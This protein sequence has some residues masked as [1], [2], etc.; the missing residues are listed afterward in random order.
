MCPCSPNDVS[1]PS[2]TVPSGP[3]IPGFG[4]PFALP[5][6][7]NDIAGTFNVVNG[8]TTV[9]LFP[10]PALPQTIS[11][12]LG[13]TLNFSSQP[14]NAY[15]VVFVGDTTMNVTP[16]YTG[17]TATSVTASIP[18]QPYPPAGFPEDLLNLF[19]QFQ[20]LI[21]PG[22]LKPSLNPNF[23]KDIFDTILSMMDQFFPFLMLYKFFL[24]VLN[25]IICIIEVLCALMNPF[26]LISAINRLFSQC[27]PEFLNLFPIFA[28]VIMIISLLSLLLSLIEYIASQILKLVN[29]ILRN[30]NA[31]TKAFQDADANGVLAIAQ[32]L[33]SLLCAFQNVFV[34]LSIF[35]VVI[36]V[37]KDI[38]RLSFPIP[39]CESGSNSGCCSTT[40]CP[41][42]ITNNY[43]NTTGTFQYLPEIGVGFSANIPGSAIDLRAESWQLYDA[44]QTQAQA[45]SNI[46]NA[47]DI[48]SSV[49]PKPIFF[50]TDSLYTATTAVNQAPYT[51]N[52]RLFYNPASWGRPGSA[53]YIRFDNCIML[54]VPSPN[55]VNYQNTN[56]SEPTGVI[57]VAGG[58][59]YED[60]NTTV[61]T[62]FASNGTTPISSQA[63]LNN[64]LHKPAT[65]T[66]TYSA[67]PP[68]PNDGYTFS[69]ATYTFTP[70]QEV[71]FNKQITTLGCEP[72]ITLNRTFVNTVL[73]GNVAVQT[74]T[75]NGLVNSNNF[76][77][78]N[79]ALLCLTTALD[80][81]RSNLSN[82]GVAQFQAVS[83]LCLN[84]LQN[85]ANTSL[86]SMVGIGF[87]PCTSTMALA[88]S[89]QFTSEKIVVSVNLNENN[90]ISLTQNLPATVAATLAQ[91][92]KG[93]PTFG[94]ITNFTYDGYQAFIA[95]ITSPA[96]GSGSLMVSFDN[97]IFC[98]NTLSADT[99][100][101]S[102]HT[103]QQLPYQFVYS[104]SVPSGEPRRDPG[105]VARDGS[106]GV[107]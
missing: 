10:N 61:L 104:P 98:T 30:I 47:F 92:I 64:F 37:I 95:E 67:P 90:G 13:T 41:E 68:L 53:R 22:V 81:L 75:L 11:V 3:P 42:I 6:T 51:I 12:A 77:D 16:G 57:Y 46:Y 102:T 21:P 18:A 38:L 62:G 55:L 105:D 91:Q 27:I 106:R 89:I 65:I 32:K 31:L 52:L 84:T 86:T 72:G 93:F 99:S 34:L 1:I 49:N 8:S 59:G 14:G 66:Y 5:S 36:E 96:A 23:S 35:N 94:D 24:P 25:L 2:P 7:S 15:Q 28:L 40:T 26:A 29:D 63:T 56:V 80:G 9:S 76:P 48:P 107:I 44:H 82:E 50:P 39:P 70:N 43:T 17:P 71:L 4:T 45:F 88:P 60:N 78:P 19:N 101:P 54:Q 100:V 69:N 103:L 33:G 83:T 58:L 73:F 74:A 87:N 79:A 85:A 97:Q 20:F